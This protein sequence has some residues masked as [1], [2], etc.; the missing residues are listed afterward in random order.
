MTLEDGRGQDGA[1]ARAEATRTLRAVAAG[2]GDE[3][4]R[5]FDLVYD[6]LR[7][8]AGAFLARE[9]A[10]HTLQP[11]A[12]VHEAWVRMIDQREDSAASRR[13]FF[14]TAARA[15]RRIL[16]DHA[17]GK[18]R[19]KRGGAWGRVEL[20]QAVAPTG[21]ESIDVTAVDAALEELRALSPR[22]A[23]I[24]ELRFF[25][26]LTGDEVAEVLG[27]SPSTVAREWRFARAWLAD[28]LEPGGP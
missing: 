21:E 19:A 1:G 22:K 3:A 18:Q 15:M 12:L 20:D 5:L 11:T 13:H 7:D 17:R 16:V 10:D 28:R 14:A 23:D 6:E 4:Q 26:G 8:L 24:V 25:A 9:R 2:R 27:T